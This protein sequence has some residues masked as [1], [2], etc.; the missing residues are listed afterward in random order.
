MKIELLVEQTWS[1]FGGILNDVSKLMDTRSV[2]LGRDHWMDVGVVLY[3]LYVGLE[4]LIRCELLYSHV[5]LRRKLGRPQMT[6]FMLQIKFATATGKF[7]FE[8]KLVQND[9]HHE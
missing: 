7:F 4:Y 6:T 9:S 5:C 8:W 3:V 1:R 2:V